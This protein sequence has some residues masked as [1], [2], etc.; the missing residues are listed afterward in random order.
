MAV[1]YCEAQGHKLLMS[2]KVVLGIFISCVLECHID[3]GG[4][5]FEVMRLNG[6]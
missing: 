1:S 4:S 5:F 2:G 6:Q 3:E